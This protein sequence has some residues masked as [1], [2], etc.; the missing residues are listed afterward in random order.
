[1]LVYF[2]LGDAKVWRWGSK[3]TP[4]PNTN[5][6]ASQWNIGLIVYMNDI[7]DKPYYVKIVC[8][9]MIVCCIYQAIIGIQFDVRYSRILNVLNI[10]EI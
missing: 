2:A 9:R 1:M 6:F 8:M 4:A 5:G 10:G 3:P 7:V